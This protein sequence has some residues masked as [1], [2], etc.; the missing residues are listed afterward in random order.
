VSFF[1]FIGYTFNVNEK[2][3]GKLDRRLGKKKAP[4]VIARIQ[5]QVRD[6]RINQFAY[7]IIVIA[8]RIISEIFNV[9]QEFDW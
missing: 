5:V 4:R 6:G 1:H 9:F 8:T 3:K 7:D 2:R